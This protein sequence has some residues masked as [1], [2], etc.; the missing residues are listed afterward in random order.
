MTPADIVAAGSFF[1]IVVMGLF[2][3]ALREIARQRPNARI[4]ARIDTL[5]DDR[6]EAKSTRPEKTSKHQLFSLER[7]RG[8]AGAWQAWFAAWRE[9]VRTVAGRSGMRTIALAAALAFVVTL[10][11]VSLLQLALVLRV[12]LPAVASLVAARSTYGWLV[13]RFKL[14][15]LSVFP[16]TLDL[17]IRA[18]RA[19]IP[20]VQAICT[21]GVEAE[22]PVRSTFR[23]MGDALLVGAEVKEVLEQAARRLQ[24]AD[25]SFFTVCLI[26]Q[27]ETGGNLADTLEN[28][29]GIV[30]SRRDIRAKTKALTAEGRIASKIISAVPFAIMAFLSV[31]NR[32]YVALLFNTRAGHKMLT[33]AAV[34]LTIGLLL[35]RKISNLDTSR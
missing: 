29:A 6:R 11:A 33:L 15:F 9:R 8:D 25:F 31:V 19:G 10:A 35:I 2:V 13:A 23:T 7:A 30:R 21:A 27:R 22:E 18:V 34:L 32:P 26:L 24:L 5:R 16:D 28:L 20:A 4:K 17:I 3:R 14:R 12:V 1:A